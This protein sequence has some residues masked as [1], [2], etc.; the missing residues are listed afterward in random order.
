[1]KAVFLSDTHKK[2]RSLDP[3]PE[4][5]L[6]IHAGDFS[7]T[8]RAAEIQDFASWFAQQ[9]HPHKILIAG[10]HDLTLDLP[11]YEQHWR[12]WHPKA[13]EPASE[14]H[15]WLSNHSGFHYLLDEAIVLDGLTIYGSP[16]QPYFFNWAFNLPRGSASAKV[17]RKIPTKTDILITHGPPQGIGD[18]C[19][20]GIHAGCAD[21]LREIQERVKPTIH[22]FGHI[23]EGYGQYHDGTTT[24]INASSCSVRY[25]PVQPPIQ[26]ELS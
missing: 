13:P 1:M 16:W 12:R 3:L 10:N 23:H 14:L 7:S 17:W 19:N 9:P 8:G 25:Q 24:Y 6:L 21:L 2:H 20:S 15:A 11:Y 4:G 18:L 22:C 5:D 26:I